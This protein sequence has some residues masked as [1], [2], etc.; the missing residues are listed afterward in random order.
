MKKIKRLELV[1]IEK[2]INFLFYENTYIND[3]IW[4]FKKI[5]NR[6]NLLDERTKLYNKNAIYMLLMRGVT[7]LISFFYVPLFLGS[8]DLSDYG[9]FITLTSVIGWFALLD[10][11]LS[12]GL[13][14]RLAEAISNN[15]VE[16]GKRL[17]STAYF[18][19]FLY[20]L[21]IFIIFIT[22]SNFDWSLVLNTEMER[23][24]EM[25]ILALIVFFT[26]CLNFI[27]GIIN[28]IFLSIQLPYYKDVINLISQVLSFLIIYIMVTHYAVIDL[29]TIASTVSFTPIIVLLLASV[30]LFKTKL[31]NISPSFKFID[32]SLIK[33]IMGIGINFFII[34]IITII[35]Y[36]TN[37]FI[38]MHTVG[39]ESVV[40]FSI[41]LKYLESIGI[42]FTILVTPIWSAS[43]EAFVKKD[44]LWI[45]KTIKKLEKVAI[46]V[47][48]IGLLMISIQKYFFE[49]W[50][51]E[52]NIYIPNSSLFLIL[53]FITARNFYQVYGYPIN[54]SGKIKAQLLIT[55]AVAVIY[56]PLTY[57]FGVHFGFN[58]V[59]SI[60]CLAQIINVVWSKYQIQLILNESAN[61]IWNK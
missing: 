47:S 45:K 58:G 1:H 38:L 28:T 27:I 52:N 2:N 10:I 37:H 43:T 29:V 7:I 39:N 17:I 54:G 33:Y 57:S 11:G 15:K 61:G 24:N 51:K 12:N 53:I 13:R 42:I 44:Y 31:K 34:Q 50:L 48:I 22:F 16:L 30:F 3:L 20:V 36:Q 25:H 19:I 5:N 18:A 26:F 4:M 8:L 41:G 55:V 35:I 49:I 14:N 9:I 23:R 59:L 46:G 21:F 6:F 40:M 60:M 56:I 32:L